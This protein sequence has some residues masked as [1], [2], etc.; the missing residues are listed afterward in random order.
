[1]H[2]DQL[3][4]LVAVI[5]HGSFEAAARAL[6]VTPPAVSQRSKA[7]ERHWG[8]VLVVRAAPCRPTAGGVVLLRL[9]RQVADLQADVMTELEPAAAHRRRHLPVVVNADSLATWFPQVL[10]D[11]ATWV[12]CTLELLIEVED[13]GA[14]HLRTGRAVGAVTSDPLPVPGC[15]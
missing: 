6:H 1:M 10:N 3:A 2:P 11:A 15:V 5:D 8:R 12:D 13:H 14:A 7:L 9:A 4:A